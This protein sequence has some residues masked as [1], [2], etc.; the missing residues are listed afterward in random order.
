MSADLIPEGFYDAVAYKVAT[1]DFGE[2]Y[3][4][5]GNSP[6]KGTPQVVVNVE[7]VGEGE[8]AGRRIAYVGYFT[9]DSIQR[10]VESLRY[11]GFRGNDLAGLVTQQLDQRVQIVV[12]HEEWKGKV[13]AKIAWV[14][15]PGGGALK[16]TQPMN[17]DNLRTFA[18]RMK[19][20]VG[21]VP[22][23][24]GTPKVSGGGGQGQR[25]SGPPPRD[26]PPP[27]G[28]DDGIPF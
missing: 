25:R 4:Q 7:I 26:E 28:D 21:M 10:T 2:T 22:D 20:A 3:A 27:H 24:G 16:L 1:E 23:S 9:D 14:N 8:W 19:G 5:V 18:A 6:E 12:R 13:R 11:F 17:K 15:R